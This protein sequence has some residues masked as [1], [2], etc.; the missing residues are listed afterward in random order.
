MN[1]LTC[2]HESASPTTPGRLAS[3]TTPELP[4]SLDLPS[5]LG[6]AAWARLPPAVRRRFALGHG[7]A[8]YAGHMTLRCSRF[9]RLLA[10]LAWPL[11]SPLVSRCLDDAPTTVTVTP[12]GDGGVIWARRMGDRTVRSIKRPHAEGGVLERTTGGLAM[13]LDVFEEDCALVFRSRHYAWCLGPFY[14]RLPQA[15][16]P[17]VCRVEHRDLGNGRF[18]F[19]L[20]MRH[21]L[22]GETFHQTGVFTDP[23]EE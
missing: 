4:A 19:T 12:D 13:A 15:L 1:T 11:R 3:P 6:D 5:L 18:R 17:G 21:P 20:S 9:G 7:P 16:S 10:W 2:H 14:L 22:L 8:R 23:D